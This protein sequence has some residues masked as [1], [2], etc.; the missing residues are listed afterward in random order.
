LK[1]VE[2]LAGGAWF[3]ARVGKRIE[4][5]MERGVDGGRVFQGRQLDGL[6]GE[7]FSRRD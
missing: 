5:G 3:D 6:T 1:A 2:E 4:N 7:G